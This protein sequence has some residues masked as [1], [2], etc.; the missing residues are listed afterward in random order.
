MTTRPAALV[1]SAVMFDGRCRTGGVV[2][3]AETVALTL[4]VAVRVMGL[5]LDAVPVAV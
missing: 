2:S 1:A 5:L 4:N 3:H